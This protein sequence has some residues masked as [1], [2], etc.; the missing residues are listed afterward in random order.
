VAAAARREA[1]V[2][3][4]RACRALG[5]NRSVVRYR[6]KASAGREALVA[7]MHELARAHPR[8]GY[9]RVWA[10]LVREGWR[11]NRKRVHRLWRREGLKVPQKQRKRRRL[12]SSANG[13]QRRRAGRVNEVWSYDFVMDQTA[14]GRRLKILPVVD[15]YTRE[16]L[17]LV[18]ARRLTAADV[19]GV[20]TGLFAER[21][22]PAYLRS[23]NG[24]EFVATAVK[25]WLARSGV[26]TLYIEPGSPWEN[27]YSESFN[28]RLTDEVLDREVFASV[29]EAAVLLS[30]YRRAYNVDR[31]HSS[32]G[33]VA[34][35][36]FAAR[37]VPPT[38][39][40]LRPASRTE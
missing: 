36:V 26:Q 38:S 4:R 19:V 35:A 16:C 9:R 23:D 8:Y 11:V 32:L 13:S 37:C 31:P 1:G 24:P 2:S 40:S 30:E 27:A 28:S 17:A 20:L 12:G 22:R 21:G 6:P 18:V 33:Y 34:P 25:T 7:R 29:K 39:A 14:D 5:V 3:E 15:E 10:L